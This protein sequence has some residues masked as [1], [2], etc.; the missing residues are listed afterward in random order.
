M[1]IG[2]ARLVH[3][4]LEAYGTDGGQMTTEDEL[5]DLVAALR[6]VLRRLGRSLKLP[7]RDYTSFRTYWLK[8]NASGS[9]Q[10]RRD[11]LE[12]LFGPL[13][14][15]LL[16][17]EE[18]TFDALVDPVSPHGSTGWPRVDE[19]IRELR[20][21]FQTAST[22]QDYRALGTNCVGVLEALGKVVYDPARHL[23]KGE[24]EPPVDKTKMRIGRYVEMTLPGESNEE[25]RGV[26]NKVIELAHHVKH[27]E[28]ATRR[29]AGIAADSV[30]LLANML[31]RL[32]RD[33]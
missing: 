21:R 14:E 18:D 17:L 29:S 5:V 25:L 13:H 27:S 9:W 16:S 8:E 20:R 31:R 28:T 23:R 10:A 19:E 33:V 1:A 22:S 11:L 15:Q 4:E 30:I 7:F 12:T 3:D 24:T 6:A 26:A 32:D 2:L